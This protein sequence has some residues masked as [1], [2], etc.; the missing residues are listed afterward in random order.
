MAASIQDYVEDRKIN[1]LV[2]FTKE[3][4]LP[5]ILQRG[6]VTRDILEKEGF[7]NFNDKCRYD[8]TNAVCLSIGFPNYKMFYR[9]RQENLDASWV[10]IGIRPSVLWERKVVFC[11]SNAAASEVTV[12]PMPQRMGLPAFQRMYGDLDGKERQLLKIPDAYPTNP[13]AEVMVLNGVPKEYIMGIG[14]IDSPTEKKLSFL[15]PNLNIKKKEDFFSY[16]K[17][18]EHWNR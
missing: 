15:F 16:R 14:T 8:G 9:L 18:F 13:Q 12:I 11:S 17:D 1:Y 10:V 7:V 6:L 4:N 5:S 3:E 2:H